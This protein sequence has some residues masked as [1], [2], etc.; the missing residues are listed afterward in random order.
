MARLPVPSCCQ[1]DKRYWTPHH[2][3]WYYLIS[4][5]ISWLDW[6]KQTQYTDCWTKKDYTTHLECKFHDET[7]PNKHNDYTLCRVKKDCT[8]HL[9]CKQENVTLCK[10]SG[11][12][13]PL[14][15]RN[16]EMCWSKSVKFTPQRFVLNCFYSVLHAMD[17]AIHSI[18]LNWWVKWTQT[19][20]NPI[21]CV[22]CTETVCHL[23]FNILSA[24]Y[25]HLKTN[26]RCV[27]SFALA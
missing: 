20:P 5:Q 10:V 27:K 1:R 18:I 17:M 14:L 3:L 21:S 22:N 2:P 25:G 8:A 19:P 12:L 6:A 24:A 4:H 26:K 23:L 9:E 11:T 13:C 15:V 16:H 7:E